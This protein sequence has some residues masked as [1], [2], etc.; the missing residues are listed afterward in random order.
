MAMRIELS[1]QP[2]LFLPWRQRMMN[3]TSSSFALIMSFESVFAAIAGAIF[4]KEI[5]TTREILACMVLFSGI[6]IAQFGEYIFN[7]IRSKNK[8]TEV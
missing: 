6:I 5:M 2:I 7:F 4:L 3:L 8:K 1:A